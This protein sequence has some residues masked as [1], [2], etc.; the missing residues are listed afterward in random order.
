MMGS[1]CCGEQSICYHSVWATCFSFYRCLVRG[2]HLLSVHGC[3]AI[4]PC[5]GSGVMCGSVSLRF[6]FI[7]LMLIKKGG[8]CGPLGLH[9]MNILF[10]DFSEYL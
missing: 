6:S 10:S 9:V 2:T 8:F 3:E 7:L 4:F 5:A 1:A